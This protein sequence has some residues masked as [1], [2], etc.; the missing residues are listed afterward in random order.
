MRPLRKN[1]I[2]TGGSRGLGLGIIRTLV[3]RG[4]GV[5][6]CS[7]SFT[8]EL[9]KLT[10]DAPVFWHACEIG[11]SEQTE[12]FFSLAETWAGQNGLWGLVNNAGI[13]GNGV[14]AT[15]PV[16]EIEKIIATN[17]TGALYMSRLILRHFLGNSQ[18]GRII[19][20]SSIIG[21]RGYTG[22]AAYSASKAGMDGMTRALAREMG[23]KGITV[24][25]VNPGYLE[26]EMSSVLSDNQRMQIVNRTPLGR[27]GTIHDISPVVAFLLSE[28]AGFMT[29]Q[30]LVVDGGITA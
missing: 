22:L 5:A 25:S 16:V 11:N 12:E 1:V 9:E 19:N 24:N 18:G 26:T 21:L 8:P 30:T 13:A 3:M 20:V 10:R 2:V 7:R 15:Y 14:L 27:L 28:E 4:Y 6:T 23:R 17:L 29:G